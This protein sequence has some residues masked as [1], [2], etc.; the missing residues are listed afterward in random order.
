MSADFWLKRSSASLMILPIGT[1]ASVMFFQIRHYCPNCGN[2][3]DCAA[4]Q[5]GEAVRRKPDPSDPT[6]FTPPPKPRGEKSSPPEIV[7]ACAMSRCPIC[8]EPLLIIF[9][10]TSGAS[11]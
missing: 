4:S 10:S 9:R 11:E 6:K 8:A 5:I 2:L 3:V 1:G 7:E